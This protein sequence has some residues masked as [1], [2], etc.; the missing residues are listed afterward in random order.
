M[1][2]QNVIDN[3]KHIKNCYEISEGKIIAD[4]NRVEMNIIYSVI[5]GREGD[6]DI[7][8]TY[9]NYDIDTDRNTNLLVQPP[10]DSIYETYC[11]AQIDLI[12][13]ESERYTNNMIVY[14]Q[15][16]TEFSAFWCKNHRQK[17]RYNFHIM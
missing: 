11:C 9:G 14:N 13:E 8:G 2:I 16:L 1:T 7:V 3:V 5:N 12:Y 4:I 10:Y 6:N 15:L 17:K